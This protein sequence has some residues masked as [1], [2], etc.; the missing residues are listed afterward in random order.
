M[1]EAQQRYLGQKDLMEMR[2]V[3][4]PNDSGSARA[5]RIVDRRIEIEKEA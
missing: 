3:L 5:R 2:P 1:L 4:L